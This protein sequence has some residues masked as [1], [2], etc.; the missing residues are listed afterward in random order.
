MKTYYIFRHAIT[1]YSKN[2]LPYGDNQLT[3]EILEEGIPPIERLALHLKNLKIDAFYSSELLRCRQTSEIASN[4]MNIP[5]ETDARINEIYVNSPESFN[6][7]EV[8]LKH[9]L[10]STEESLSQSIAICT[11]GATIAGLK[12]II[13]TGSFSI[14]DLSDYPK[15]GEL[16]TVTSKKLET[17]D[18]NA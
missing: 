17:V 11:H 14:I 6:N 1:F 13:M 5:F 8:R 16:W 4:I 2:G 7:F 12:N 3:A 9:F 18:F 15:S 10:K